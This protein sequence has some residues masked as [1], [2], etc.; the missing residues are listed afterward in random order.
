MTPWCHK[1]RLNLTKSTI[2][3]PEPTVVTAVIMV[4]YVYYVFETVTKI[5]IY[6][7]AKHCRSESAWLRMT[8]LQ[9]SQQHCCDTCK[10][11]WVEKTHIRWQREAWLTS[12]GCLTWRWI[13]LQGYESSCNANEDEAC[14]DNNVLVD[15]FIPEDVSLEDR[16]WGP[17]VDRQVEET[18]VMMTLPT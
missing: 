16:R 7:I 3:L 14:A 17:E 6:N 13:W 10:G 1:I 4:S 11:R 5:R 2:I 18:N 8:H 12:S 9:H 15:D